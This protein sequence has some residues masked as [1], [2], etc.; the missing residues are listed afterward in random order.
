MVY[1][2][3]T[4]QNHRQSCLKRYTVYRLVSSPCQ[5]V[6]RFHPTSTTICPL[7]SWEHLTYDHLTMSRADLFVLGEV[8]FQANIV[9]VSTHHFYY[10][11]RVGFLSCHLSGSHDKSL[12]WE[13]IKLLWRINPLKVFKTPKPHAVWMLEL[14]DMFIRQYTKLPNILIFI[15]SDMCL[16]DVGWNFKTI[17]QGL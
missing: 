15:W 3:G 10:S 2:L 8:S 1:K 17:W 5:M 11:H 13:C 7:K 4:F 6:P 9:P 14:L 16:V 12:V